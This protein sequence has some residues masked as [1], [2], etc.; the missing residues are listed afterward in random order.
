MGTINLQNIS[1][2]IISITITIAAS[3]VLAILI[4]ESGNFGVAQGQLSNST[5][6]HH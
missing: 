5:H 2:G 6:H 3:I 4:A 1:V